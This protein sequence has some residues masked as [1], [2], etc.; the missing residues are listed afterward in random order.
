MPF[1][2][3]RPFVAL[4]FWLS[5]VGSLAFSPSASFKGAF[6]LTSSPEHSPTS[7]HLAKP[8]KKRRRRKEDD[9]SPDPVADDLPDFDLDEDQPASKSKPS[10]KP[11]D[12]LGEISSA[13]MG[14]SNTPTRSVN[15]LIADRSLEKAFEFDEEEDASLPD[16]AVMAKEN[17]KG[18][19]KARRNARVAA[20]V[21]KKEDEEQPNPLASIPFI[22][23]EK[24]EVS[25]VKIL[26]SGAWLG[27]FALVGWE[28][29]INSPL[30]ERAAAPA[31]F[32]F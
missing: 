19:K 15:Q 3:K 26:E 8:K 4:I 20:A 6:K 23:D 27:I 24:G 18:K 13:M 21:A 9:D 14:S 7:L 11:S 29:Y 32:L 22:T 1:V 28:F 25:A 16:L 12:P 5:V 10:S 17:E 2:Q 31:P 30:F